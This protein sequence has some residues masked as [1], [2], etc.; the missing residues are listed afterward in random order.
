M[1]PW[2]SLFAV[3]AGMHCRRSCGYSCPTILTAKD[4]LSLDLIVAGEA[5]GARRVV[6]PQ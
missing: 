3:A 5:G 4:T 2:A 6:G 1:E